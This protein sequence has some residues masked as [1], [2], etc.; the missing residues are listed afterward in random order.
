VKFFLPAIVGFAQTRFAVHHFGDT[1]YHP[2]ILPHQRYLDGQKI[3][4]FPLDK[5][6]ETI[7]TISCLTAEDAFVPDEGG[8]K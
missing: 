2:R 3:K 6:F 1:H 5:E 8:M 7:K 4:M